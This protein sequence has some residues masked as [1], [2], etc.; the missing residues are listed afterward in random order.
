MYIEY[1]FLGSIQQDMGVYPENQICILAI[2]LSIP[3]KKMNNT[4]LLLTKEL[5]S[6]REGG[7][8]IRFK[9]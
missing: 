8:I 5:A 3:M 9:G 1:N 2:L 4:Q 7:S 6:L